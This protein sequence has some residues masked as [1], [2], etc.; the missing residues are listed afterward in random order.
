MVITGIAFD[1]PDLDASVARLLRN[2]PDFEALLNE[3]YNRMDVQTFGELLRD[4]LVIAA[5]LVQAAKAGDD[6]AVS[7]LTTRWYE[8]ADQIVEQMNR[9]NRFWTPEEMRPLWHRHLDLTINEAVQIL[10][11]EYA[12]SV[13]TFDEIEREALL[14]ADAFWRGIVRQFRI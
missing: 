13:T 14:M 10:G 9:M 1:S 7:D 4:H 5:E 6:Q 2:V 11:G 12:E 8:N 3:F